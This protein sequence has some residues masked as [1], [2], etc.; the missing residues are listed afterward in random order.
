MSDNQ[1]VVVLLV[2]DET[3]VRV[4][5]TELLTD[6]GG[7]KVVGATNADEAL[8]ILRARRDVRVLFT[9]I[10]M[11]G[12]IDGLQLAHVVHTQWPGLPIIVTSARC[13]DG[14]LPNGARF[15]AKPYL[16]HVLIETIREFVNAPA[17]QSVVKLVVA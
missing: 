2:E 15:L 4:F 7:F 13:P 14:P 12:S 9:D 6:D 8:T 10:T 11:P 1:N 16:P 3:L 5:T 17:G